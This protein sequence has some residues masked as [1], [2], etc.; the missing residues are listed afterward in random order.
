MTVGFDLQRPHVMAQARCLLH[1]G[2]YLAVGK[3]DQKLLADT[4][5]SW[6]RAN[7]QPRVT[8]AEVADH[9]DHVK[10][11]IG[12]ANIGISGDYDGIEFTIEGLGDVSKFPSLLFELARRGWSEAELKK[13]T[14]QNFLRVF[15]Q[16]E[17]NRKVEDHEIKRKRG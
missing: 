10:G 2:F 5:K 8:I 3:H 14:G 11:V 7:P 15:E 9:F 13:I 16:V 6:E 12:V 4:M 17:R 1:R